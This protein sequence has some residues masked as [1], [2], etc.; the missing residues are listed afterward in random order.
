[1]GP[2]PQPEQYQRQQQTARLMAELG[3][4]GA[5]IG[6][7]SFALHGAKKLYELIDGIQGAPENIA[8]ISTDL[9]AFYQVLGTLESIK[10]FSERL[11]LYHYLKAPLDNCVKI[12]EDLTTKLNKCTHPTSK[13]TT[14]KRF[15]SSIAWAFKGNEIQTLRGTLGACKATLD[16]A[17]VAI[18]L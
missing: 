12:F 2:F 13:Y 18:N 5:S 8:A 3:A 11:Q 17:I 4:A 6:I 16:L 14:R 7:I 1:V 15:R 10:G 9:K